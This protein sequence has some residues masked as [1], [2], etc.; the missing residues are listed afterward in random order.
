M[1]AGWDIYIKCLKSLFTQ[2]TANNVAQHGPYIIHFI[3]N[4]H[5]IFSIESFESSNNKM[6]VT[7]H[8][9][10]TNTVHEKFRAK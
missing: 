3:G 8:A 4:S 10:H 2:C 9:V 7:L 6:F 5:M 1:I